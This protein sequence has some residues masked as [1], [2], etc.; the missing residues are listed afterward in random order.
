MVD[1]A[2]VSNKIQEYFSRLLAQSG[3]KICAITISKGVEKGKNIVGTIAKVEVQDSEN[4]NKFY[5]FIIKSAP[6]DLKFRK[7]IQSSILFEREMYLYTKVLPEF[8]KFQQE[9]NV[10]NPFQSYAKYFGATVEELDEAIVMQDMVA[11]GYKLLN[12]EKSLDY[13]HIVLV[14]KEYGKFHALSYALRERKPQV[15][16]ELISNTVEDYFTGQ[17]WN[18]LKLPIQMTLQKAIKTI[19]SIEHEVL[20]KKMAS[21]LNKVTETLKKVLKVE[22]PTKYD[23]IGHGDC[24]INNIL[25][26]YENIENP[27][28]P[29]KIC[30]IDWQFSR[31]GSPAL[32][33][34]YF[35]FTSTDTILRKKHYDNFIRE[36]HN[37]L[38]SFYSKLTDKSEI[39]LPYKVLQEHLRKFSIY[40][41]L[42]SIQALYLMLN[43]PKEEESE[44]DV[45][46]VVDILAYESTNMHEYNIRIKDMILDFDQLGYNFE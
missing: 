19:N 44:S 7:F 22:T 14:L 39:C 40:G 31:V 32:D 6:R 46:K 2:L 11:D 38:C 4:E 12:S 13:E 42:M 35:L 23:V 8:D 25:F 29:T 21:F 16:S 30:F 5:Y 28:F 34:S 33:I 27:N 24:W 18:T 15:F 17:A 20:H 45:T 9:I 10:T 36:Y 43:K 41:L 37:S 26:K 3:I 1:E